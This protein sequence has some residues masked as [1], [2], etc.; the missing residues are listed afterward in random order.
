MNETYKIE[1]NIPIPS[2]SG[3][4]CKYPWKEMEVGDSLLVLGEPLGIVDAPSFCAENR[5]KWQNIRNTLYNSA[6]R[7][8]RTKKDGEW[9]FTTSRVAGGIRIWRTK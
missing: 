7:F 9:K 5:T 8:S 3:R 6:C 4:K 2:R 1:K